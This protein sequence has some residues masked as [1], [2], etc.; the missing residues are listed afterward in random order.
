MSS[1]DAAQT[2]QAAPTAPAHR[3]AVEIR[4]VSRTYG[5]GPSE[6]LALKGIDFKIPAQ[7]FLSIVGPS[8]CGKS[9]LLNILAGFDRP[10]TGLAL[11]D[12]A[13]ISGPSAERGVV[14]QDTAALFPW[15][16]IADNVGFGLRAA[17]TAKAE[18]KA[19]V[20]DALALVGLTAFADKRPQQ[21]SGG[22]RQ[23]VALAR[24]LVMKPQLLLMDEPFA[25]LDA[26]T[27]L[28][29]QSHLI[30]IWQKTRI[31]ILLITHS[32][33]EAIYLGD[34]VIVLSGRPGTVQARLPVALERPRDVTSIAFNQI[35]AEALRHLGIH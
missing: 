18:T 22:M 26:L 1:F 33:E 25:A 2:V 10:S 7:S 12:G 30:G 24:V 3:G 20:A 27:R 4:D 35:K 29:M 5:S 17:G 6:V 23:L 13:G 15:L 8:G 31:T 21:L 32:V 11:V 14:F 34:E 19:R 28:K 9:T 16:T